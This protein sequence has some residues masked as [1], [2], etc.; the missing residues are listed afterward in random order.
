MIIVTGSNGLLGSALRNRVE[1]N[2]NFI[3]ATRQHF[4]V[5]DEQQTRDFI[6]PIVLDNPGNV[7]TVHLAAYTATSKAEDERE[8]CYRANVIGTRNVA[9]ASPYLLYVSTDHV[10]NGCKGDYSEA[11]EPCPWNHYGWTKLMGE[12]EAQLA[13]AEKNAEDC[14]RYGSMARIIRCTFRPKPFPYPVAWN[15]VFTTAMWVEDMA[16]ALEWCI[17]NF[18]R[19][20]PVLHIGGKK[21]DYHS[22]AVENGPVTAGPAPLGFPKDLSLDSS[23]YTRLRGQL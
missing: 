23:N 5:E 19:L 3:W 6:T 21:Q 2:P 16:E 18:V 15:D 7:V 14:C 11:D 9:R 12:R 17:N 22:F 10:F 13:C 8:K 4:N 1:A 20:P